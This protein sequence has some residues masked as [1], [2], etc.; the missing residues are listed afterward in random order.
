MDK[1]TLS[2]GRSIAYVT[3]SIIEADELTQRSLWRMLHCD[4][5]LSV[6]RMTPPA[7]ALSYLPDFSLYLF[8]LPPLKLQ[9][10]TYVCKFKIV[11]STLYFFGGN[12]NQIG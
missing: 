5:Y 10:M 6:L 9:N 3:E 2:E 1:G 11:V 7:P 12:I 8:L 4:F